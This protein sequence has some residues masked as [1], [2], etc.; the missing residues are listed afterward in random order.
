MNSAGLLI[1]NNTNSAHPFRLDRSQ[2]VTCDNNH[3]YAQHFAI[4]DNFYGST[5]GPSTPGHI[6]LISGQTIG[7]L[8]ANTKI[9]PSLK[10]DGVVNGTLI[11]DI[12]P[13]FD[14]CSRNSKL[15]NVTVAMQGKNIG[16]LM[17]AK[18]VT[19][20]WFSGE[21]RLLSNTGNATLDCNSR[22]SHT[23]TSEIPNK[24][25]YPDVESFQYYNSTANPHHLPP[26]SVE[27]VGHTDQANHQYDLTHFW[28][29]SEAGNMPSVSFIKAPTYQ[30]GHPEISDPLA[31]HFFLV[32]TVNRLE[33]LPE[34]NS[35][36]VI[37]TWDDSDGWYDQVM[38]PI[39][40]QSD[41]PVN[42]ALLGRQGLCGHA[43]TGAA[44]IA[45]D[46]VLVYL[47]L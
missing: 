25:Y 7:A 18:G 14:D 28:N 32:N 3:A 30:D 24:D 5:F 2:V 27:M 13:R 43:H 36:A 20:G 29:A 8:P 15:Y 1:N 31:E 45:A 37:I 22:Q 44:K 46:M 19:W 4:S 33:S 26:T 38:P 40:S 11:G 17:N 39:V 34:W 16:D 41:D 47:C 42:D 35:T 21:F 6:N 12:D 23:S 10:F 9:P